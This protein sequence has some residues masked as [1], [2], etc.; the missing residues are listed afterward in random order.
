MKR[1]LLLAA[2]AFML[3]SCSKS[4]NGSEPEPEKPIG[5]TVTIGNIAYPTISIGSQTWTTVNYRGDGGTAYNNASTVDAKQGKLYTWAEATAISVPN[6]WRLP[7]LVDYKALAASQGGTTST[8]SNELLNATNTKKLLSKDWTTMGGTNTSGFNAL[9][10]GVYYG[11]RFREQ[12]T[13]TSFWTSLQTNTQTAT[14][15]HVIDHQ[16]PSVTFATSS[17]SENKTEKFSIRFVKDN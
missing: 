2:T 6:G 15:I 3:S 12:G 9:P 1:L 14:A 4:N 5:T 10:V 11:N 13:G 7:T 8:I 17:D 16:D